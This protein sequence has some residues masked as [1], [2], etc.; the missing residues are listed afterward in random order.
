MRLKE[1]RNGKPEGDR[2]TPIKQLN[3]SF[4]IPQGD[5]QDASKGRFC[6]PIKEDLLTVRAL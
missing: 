6:L 1:I 5:M 2:I 3:L 4:V